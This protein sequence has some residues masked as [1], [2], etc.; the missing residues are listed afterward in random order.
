MTVKEAFDLSS[1]QQE[2]FWDDRRTLCF[3]AGRG[4]GKTTAACMRL[5]GMVERGDIKDYG[6]ILV[7]APDYTQLKDGTLKSFDRWFG[8][9]P[10]N[11]HE[12]PGANLIVHKV[13]GNAPRRDLIRGI[14]VWFRSAMNP[15]QT[16]SKECQ[17]VWLDEYA[18]MTDDML[19]LTNANLR[20]FGQNAF[21]QTIITTTPRGKNHLYRRFGPQILNP[22]ND[23]PEV[24][25]YR[26]TTL[27]AEAEGVAMPGYSASLGYA[28]GSQMWKQEVEADFVAWTGNVFNQN[29]QIV[30][31]IPP[32]QYVFGGVDVGGPAPSAIELVGMTKAGAVYVFG[33]KYQ[34]RMQLD[35]LVRTVGEKHVEHKVRKWHV[36]NDI[37]WRMMNRAGFPCKPPYKKKDA[38]AA[39]I[40]YINQLISRKMFHIHYECYG[41]IHE[42][43]TYEYKEVQSGDEVTFLDKVK[44]NQLDHA[45]DALRYAVLPLSAAGAAQQYG[46]EVAFAFS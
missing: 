9:Y 33:E 17:A 21:Y 6:R 39:A 7:I 22:E 16:R 41:L 40:D 13:D 28:E 46:K 31:A 23:D 18:Q 5:L 2:F 32:L 37:I 10:G 11:E 38:A 35:D 24:G 27:Q 43:Q 20:Q 1:Y 15:D 36:D 3:V 12:P 4:S 45:I 34:P 29:W 25:A 8:D 26:V 42:M 44:P 14:E 19:T 30:D